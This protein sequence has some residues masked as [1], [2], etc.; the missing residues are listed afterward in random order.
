MQC[1]DGF[2]YSILVLY[3]WHKSDVTCSLDSYCQSSLMFCTVSCD[4]SRKDFS[5]FRDI[6]L[7]FVYILVIDFVVFF[8]TENADFFSSASAAS[9]LEAAFWTIS[10]IVSHFG[11]SFQQNEMRQVPQHGTIA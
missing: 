10:F 11:F 2:Q 8:T 7:Q 9:S 4:S 5:S 3:V 6:S 1:T